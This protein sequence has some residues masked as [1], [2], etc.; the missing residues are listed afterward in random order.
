MSGSTISTTTTATGV[1]PVRPTDTVTS[2]TTTST[3]D[4]GTCP[5]GFYACSAYY[6][7][8]G[9]CRVGRDCS[10]TSCPATSSTTI[11]SNG[12][13]IVVPVGTAAAVATPT[14]VC[15][16]GW[17]TCA[18]SVGGNCCPSGYACG[19]ASCSLVSPTQT[20]VVQ[21]GSP[22]AGTRNRG[23]WGSGVAFCLLLVIMVV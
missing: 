19:T 22:S 14:G 17:S 3:T 13:T 20:S 23:V 11:I 8:A 21:K 10:S 4:S 7:G 16:S 6:P 5:T 2:P 18:A 1:A 12:L 15:A 9:C